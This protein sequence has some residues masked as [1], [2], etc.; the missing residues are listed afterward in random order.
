MITLVA[1]RNKQNELPPNT[2]V[3]RQRLSTA[4]TAAGTV[5]ADSASYRERIV[6]TGRAVGKGCLD[7]HVIPRGDI[8]IKR[9]SYP[10]ITG[11]FTERVGE[12]NAVSLHGESRVTSNGV[13]FHGKFAPF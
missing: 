9:M 5:D 12:L 8:S 6:G 2:T 7:V 3:A 13:E 1:N 11:F 4:G 10:Q